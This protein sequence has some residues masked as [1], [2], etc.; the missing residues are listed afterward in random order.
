VDAIQICAP[1]ICDTT[2]T[3]SHNTAVR[4]QYA[5]A[6]SIFILSSPFGKPRSGDLEKGG[7]V[8]IPGVL[9]RKPSAEGCLQVGPILTLLYVAVKERRGPGGLSSTLDLD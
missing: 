4:L 3:H 1:A 7:T 5:T 8:T 6:R 2:T 9:C